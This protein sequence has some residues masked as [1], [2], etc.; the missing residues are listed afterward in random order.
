MLDFSVKKETQTMDNFHHLLD[1]ITSPA[2]DINF[3]EYYVQYLLD[4]NWQR[5]YILT[6]IINEI[7]EGQI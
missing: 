6:K 1:E 7:K 2:P 3:I 4:N 5:G